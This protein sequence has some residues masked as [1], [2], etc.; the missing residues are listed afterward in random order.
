MAK[1]Q[2]YNNRSGRQKP[3]AESTKEYPSNVYDI[4][5]YG[6]KLR[7]LPSEKR[8]TADM[9]MFFITLVLLAVGLVMVLSSSSYNALIHNNGDALYYFKR[10][11]VFMV[12]GFLAMFFM[13]H[14]KPEMVKQLLIPTLAICIFMLVILPFVGIEVNGSRRWLGTRSIRFAPAELTKPVIIVFFATHS[15]ESLQ[16]IAVQ[17]EMLTRVLLVSLGVT[18][19]IFNGYFLGHILANVGQDLMDENTQ[20]LSDVISKVNQ[21]MGKLEDASSS[22]VCIS[23]EENASMEEIASVTTSIVG[24]TTNIVEKTGESKNKLELLKQK[25]ENITKEMKKMDEISKNIVKVSVTNEEAL[26]N[27]QGISEIISQS[28]TNTLTVTSKLQNKV[29]EIDK[30]LQLIENIAEE[31]NLLALNASIEAAR[32]GEEG[33]GF[34]VVAEQVKKL[35]ENTSNSLQNVQ[36]VIREFKRDTEEVEKLMS[37]NVEQVDK[38]G[39]LIDQTVYAIKDMIKM[40]DASAEQVVHVEKLTDQQYVYTD[41]TVVF[42]DEVKVCI[43]E[44]VSRI[45]DIS[46]L[47]DQNRKAIEQITLQVEAL[48]S[49]VGDIQQV[50]V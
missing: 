40:L 12:A 8:G 27:V 26:N 10:Q 17:D 20:K 23:E 2:M 13:I 36:G 1:K 5:Q 42:N 46:E 29:Q 44:Q 14:M 34:A 6:Q 3:S 45:E 11:I 50:L 37:T 47:I 4:R 21:L 22:L 19:I 16:N 18:G 9:L 43:E 30:L 48:N 41:E 38:Q 25:V 7:N 49:I 33:K 31:T 35:S 39:E 28:T 32:A 15:I 24:D